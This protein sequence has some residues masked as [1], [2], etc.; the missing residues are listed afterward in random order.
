MSELFRTIGEFNED[1]AAWDVSN[2]T[3]MEFMF[4]GAYLF[5]QPILI[6]GMYPR[7]QT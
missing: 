1:I 2:V 4:C 5:N 3:T 6:H 7:L